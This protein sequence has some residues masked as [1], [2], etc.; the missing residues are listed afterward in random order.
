MLVPR[1]IACD[2]RC[3]STV[4]TKEMGCLCSRMA[5]SPHPQDHPTRRYVRLHLHNDGSITCCDGIMRCRTLLPFTQLGD[6]P[7]LHAGPFLCG[8]QPPSAKLSH[9]ITF[10]ACHSHIPPTTQCVGPP[11]YQVASVVT[12]DSIH[13]SEQQCCRGNKHFWECLTH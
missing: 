11:L 12:S 10:L 1:E 4:T 7:T 2:I 6:G 13:W 9:P 3:G 8:G 5:N